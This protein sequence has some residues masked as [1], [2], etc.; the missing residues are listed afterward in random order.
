MARGQQKAQAQQ[1]RA[2]ELEKQKKSQSHDQ[3]AAAKKALIYSCPVCK[4]GPW[5]GNFYFYCLFACQRVSVG[6]SRLHKHAFVVDQI[7][8]FLEKGKDTT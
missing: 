8:L 2:K 6:C 7:S 1:R 3:K 5:S 4:V